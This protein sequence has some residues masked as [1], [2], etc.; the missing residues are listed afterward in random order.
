MTKNYNPVNDIRQYANKILDEYK[1]KSA[2]DFLICLP[3]YDTDKK[4]IAY[5]RPITKDYL[6]TIPKCVE[7]MSKWRIENPTIGTG[8]FVVTHERTQRWLDNLV[9]NNYDRIIFLIMDFAGNYLGHIGLAAFQYDKRSAEIDSVLRGVKHII[10][11]MMQFCMNTIMEW[12]KKILLLQ[13]ICLKV[14][15]DNI[16]AINFYE[17]CGF[18]QDVLI[19]LIKNI[20]PD[21][22]KWEISPD[23][24]LKNAERYYLKM[25]HVS[26]E[27]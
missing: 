2:D 16:H 27:D 25:I 10:P 3:V 4:I 6:E 20:L 26:Q 8:T 18:K 15:A 5:L 19:P 12:G 1:C 17:R 9:I 7:L 11:G 14:F 13:E 23:P 22:E 24:N 21:E